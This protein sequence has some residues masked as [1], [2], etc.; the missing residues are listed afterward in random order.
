MNLRF[1]KI[2]MLSAMVLTLFSC[3]HVKD[4]ITANY[5]ESTANFNIEL[6]TADRG[7]I[8]DTVSYAVTVSANEPIKSLF[9]ATEVSGAEG[10]NF[11]VSDVGNDPF[12]DHDFGTIQPGTNDIELVYHY[13]V[14]QDTINARLVFTLIDESGAKRDTQKVV[15]VP[16]ITAYSDVALYAQSNMKADGF[17]TEDGTVYYNLPDYEELTVVNQA[18]QESLDMVFLVTDEKAVLAAPYSSYFTSDMAGKN[19]TLFQKMSDVSSDDFYALNNATLSRLTEEQEVKKGT[20]QIDDVK[21]GDVIGFRTDFASAN[22]YKYGMLRVKA[23]HPTL[24]DH[25]EGVSYVIEFDVRVQH[26]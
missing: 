7:A 4:G 26:D 19:K 9:V 12:I 6:L 10:S 8:G 3:E 18:V 14:K 17:S 22:S 13:I 1:I 24:V 5:A 11:D 2:G 21:V 25:Y 15:T 20:T 23:L 16:A